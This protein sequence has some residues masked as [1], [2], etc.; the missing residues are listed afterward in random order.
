MKRLDAAIEVLLS[1]KKKFT[2][3]V[4]G[5]GS[6]SPAGTK[7]NLK[8]YELDVS[9]V[10]EICGVEQMAARSPHTAEVDGSSPP[11]ATR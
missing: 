11:A 9:T 1:Q 7:F 5:D 8:I 6:G 2:I 3:E 10:E 4:N